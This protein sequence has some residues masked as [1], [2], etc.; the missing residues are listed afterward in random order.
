MTRTDVDLPEDGLSRTLRRDLRAGRAPE[1]WVRRALAVGGEVPLP[2]LES[3]WTLLLPHLAGLALLV[4][5]GVAIALRPEAGNTLLRFFTHPG[6]LESPLRLPHL[7]P[8]MILAWVSTP[9]LI[10]LLVQGSRGFPLL[11]RRWRRWR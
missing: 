10:F 11:Q 9:F 1:T 8:E 7:S 2:P 3:R 4:G 5:L 6:I